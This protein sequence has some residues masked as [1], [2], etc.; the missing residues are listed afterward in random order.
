MHYLVLGGGDACAWHAMAK[1]TPA[2]LVSELIL[3]VEGNRGAELPTGSVASQSTSHN[4][5]IP[6]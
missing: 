4:I 2:G 1:P 3:S 5:I 6:P